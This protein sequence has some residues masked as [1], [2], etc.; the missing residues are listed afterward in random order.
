MTTEFVEPVTF[1]LNDPFL[2]DL[3]EGSTCIYSKCKVRY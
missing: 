3:G 2:R 1:A